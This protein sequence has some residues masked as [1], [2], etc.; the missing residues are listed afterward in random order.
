MGLPLEHARVE[1]SRAR[2]LALDTAGDLDLCVEQAGR[3]AAALDAVGALPLVAA[4]RRLGSLDGDHQGPASRVILFTD[5][6]D[7]TGLNVRVGDR[8]FL[9]L[10]REHNA[11]VRACLRRSSGVEF[12]HTG[13]GVAAWFTTPADAVESA[14]AMNEDL[15]RA[16]L[17]HPDLPL[18]VRCGISS[19]EPLGNEGD[20][21][22]LSV[23]RAARLCAAATAGEV[24]VGPEIV[25]LARA[26]GV[27]FRSRG[28]MLLKGFPDPIEVYAAVMSAAR[29]SSR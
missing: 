20:L 22:G 11:V 25:E 17:L 27:V 5:L 29:A 4:A 10:V 8:A 16:S 18:L 23:V 28:Q 3:A 15:D 14:M 24:L 2:L 7:S 21:F 26:H 19:G 6:V 13:D 12:K 1:L 9:E